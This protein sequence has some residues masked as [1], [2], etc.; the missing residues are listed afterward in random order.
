MTQKGHSYFVNLLNKYYQD[1]LDRKPD[2]LG[3]EHY[4]KLLMDGQ[5]NENTLKEKYHM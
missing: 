3:F 2:Q 4:L 5:L 1:Y